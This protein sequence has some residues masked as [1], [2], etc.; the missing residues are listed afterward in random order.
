MKNNRLGLAFLIVFFS[1]FLLLCLI[2]VLYL[3]PSFPVLS[4]FPSNREIYFEN[5]RLTE[6]VEMREKVLTKITL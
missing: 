3:I 5:L 6:K 2:F 4:L 1:M